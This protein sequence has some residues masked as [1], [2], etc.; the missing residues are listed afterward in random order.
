M[1]S[2]MSF[3][4]RLLPFAT[5]GTPI[6]QDIIHLGVIATLLY[7]APQIQERFRQ[8]EHHDGEPILEH[9]LHEEVPAEPEQQINEEE[10]GEHDRVGE[11][12]HANQEHM[13]DHDAPHHPVEGEA[14]PANAPN[15]PAQRNVG[16]KK[17]KS[18][19]RKDQRRAYNEFMR[20]QGEAQRARDAEGAA[21]REA[22]LDAERERRRIA[23]SIVEGK[24][25]REREQRKERERLERETEISRRDEAL[26]MV[27]RELNEAG[28][29]NLFDIASNVGADADEVWVER[30]L[31]A[32]GVLGWS[33]DG[34]RLTLI[35]STGWV[36]RISRH[37]MQRVYEKAASGGS[38]DSKGR[39]SFEDIGGLLEEVLRERS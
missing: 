21:E 34:E 15:M 3:I 9:G 39:I 38:A 11:Q 13:P 10:D 36:A 22:E 16:A 14:G 32:G 8:H 17:S 29:V 26:G 6:L 37:D 1:A 4:N 7:F 33:P 24:R 2:L 5:P 20:S 35:L 18:L 25:A 30:I 12:E 28:M 27:R 19:A 23:A 31:N